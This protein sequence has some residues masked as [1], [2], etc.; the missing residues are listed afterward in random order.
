MVISKFSSL[1]ISY[2]WTI[3][4][5]TYI[6][7][8][9]LIESQSYGKRGRNRK[10]AGVQ[11]KEIFHPVV[12]SPQ[13]WT[14]SGSSTCVV[15]SETEQLELKL[16]NTWYHQHGWHLD[17][18]YDT[19]VPRDHKVKLLKISITL[20]TFLFWWWEYFRTLSQ[21]QVMIQYH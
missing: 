10:R 12:H 5:K 16:A 8:I 19:A 2:S 9:N 21:F 14:L 4:S 17:S 13:G 3:F 15:W 11:D 6:F 18:L 7:Y 20:Y 1:N